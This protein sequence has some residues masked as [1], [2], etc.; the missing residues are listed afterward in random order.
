M[1]MDKSRIVELEEWASDLR[2]KLPVDDVIEAVRNRMRA[3]DGDETYHLTLILKG[4]LIEVGRDQEAARVLDEMIE[5]LPNDVR[6]PIAKASLDFYFL[7]DP[8]GALASIDEALVR[9]RRTGFFR[10]EALGV[11]ARILL[12]LGLGRQLS[13]ILE[14]IMSLE[15]NEAV[16]DVGRERDFID[17]A[18]PGLISD[19][20][21]ARYDA[22]CPKK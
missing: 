15:M 5:R 3:A 8:E 10:R 9:A 4:L 12:K 19:D 22:F 11:K 18:P 14:E 13:Q 2:M 1:A 21:R 16:P 6:F 17:R 7:H 20:L